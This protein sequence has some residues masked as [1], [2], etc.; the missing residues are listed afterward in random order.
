MLR[1]SWATALA[2]VWCA[3][4]LLYAGVIPVLATLLLGAGA[5]S[6][7]QFRRGRLGQGFR[8]GRFVATAEAG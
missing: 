8:F 4:L 2:F 3:A 1:W 5:K 7:G 6:L